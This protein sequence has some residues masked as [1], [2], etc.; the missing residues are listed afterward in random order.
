M[1]LLVQKIRHDAILPTY[2]HDTDAGMDIYTP[3]TVELAPSARVLAATGIA[4]AVPAGYVGLV[5]DKSGIATRHGIVTVAGVIDA[6]YRGEVKI[7]LLNTGSEHHT[8]A[9]GQKIA[10]LLIQPVSCPAIVEATTLTGTQRGTGGF[11]S[12][13]A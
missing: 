2:A 1:K 10:Q 9:P 4:L 3:D 12:T 11:G 7:G 5:W 6:G 8:F 13:G